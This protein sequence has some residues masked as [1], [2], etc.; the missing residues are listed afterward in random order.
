MKKVSVLQFAIVGLI[1]FASVPAMGQP[2]NKTT[3][4]QKKV[5]SAKKELNEAKENLQEAH[6]DS[7]TDFKEFKM[8]AETKI[9][10]NKARI[11]ELKSDS[12]K[13][14]K[15][16]KDKLDKKIMALEQKNNTLDTKRKESDFTKTTLWTTFKHEFTHDMDELGH[17][18]KDAGVKNTK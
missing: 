16:T 9:Q 5:D 17:A 4:E 3:K 12:Q 18:F 7:A 6:I 15:A 8:N 2:G 11:V 14:D 1:A 10:A 13:Q